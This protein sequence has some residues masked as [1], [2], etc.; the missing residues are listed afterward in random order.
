MGKYY[1]MLAHCQEE[2]TTYSPA[3]G[4]LQASPFTP[5][6]SARLTGIR[7]IVNR[8]AATTLTDGVQIKLT[9]TTFKPNSIEVF[10]NGSGLQTAPAIAVGPI[11]FDVDQPVAAGVPITV[12]SRNVNGSAVTNDLVVMGRFESQ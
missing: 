8:T 5:P 4:G 2:T 6:E 10:A 9:C 1:R 3:A 7:V 12:E 11:D